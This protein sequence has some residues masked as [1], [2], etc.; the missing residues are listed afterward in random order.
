MAE[1]YSPRHKLALAAIACGK[2]PGASHS[3]P[4]PILH[5]SQTR[6]S[7]PKQS[8]TPNP[9]SHPHPIAGVQSSPLRAYRLMTM[10][11]LALCSARRR[12]FSSISSS[13]LLLGPE[14]APLASPAPA[15]PPPPVN[16]PISPSRGP[17]KE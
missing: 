2:L 10:R 5:K 8:I 1:G 3:K 4:K 12:L 15:C 13:C 17:P 11:P 6:G 7:S 9:S 16:I 14:A